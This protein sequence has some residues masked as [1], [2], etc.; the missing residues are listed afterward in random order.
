MSFPP[1][2]CLFL[3]GFLNPNMKI[4]IIATKPNLRARMS[5]KWGKL[6]TCSK[7]DRKNYRVTSSI[8][9]QRRQVVEFVA[10]DFPLFPHS[11]KTPARIL[12]LL[13]LKLKDVR[14][15]RCV[16][17]KRRKP[18]NNS[19]GKQ[20]R[21]AGKINAH[22]FSRVWVVAKGLEQVR[23]NRKWMSG[24]RGRFWMT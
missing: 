12:D 3:Q 2:E 5:W 11:T 22:R 21:F 24:T 16:Q 8:A 7:A 19:L 20:A 15:H 1:P 18:P 13:C 10:K 4:K 23:V 17:K 9:A 14:T 6:C